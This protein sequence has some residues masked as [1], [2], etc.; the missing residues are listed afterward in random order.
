MAR[1]DLQEIGRT[2]LERHGGEVYEE[3]L[4]ELQGL[5]GDRCYPPCNRNADS[6]NYLERRTRGV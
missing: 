3:F 1:V 5:R 2:G 4:V 6:R